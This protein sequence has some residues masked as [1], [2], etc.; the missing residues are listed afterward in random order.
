MYEPTA[1]IMESSIKFW[2]SM[3]NNGIGYLV[4]LQGK[5]TESTYLD[6]LKKNLKSIENELI[7]P[8]FILQHDNKHQH[9]SKIVAR[10]LQEQHILTLEDYQ[11]SSPDMSPIENMFAL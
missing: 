2:T 5:F 4:M 11:P 1:K 3:S 10:W 8:G 6:I 9:R 7:G